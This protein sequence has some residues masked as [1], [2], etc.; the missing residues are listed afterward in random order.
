M[1]RVKGFEGAGGSEG[2][3]GPK[4]AKGPKGAKG[5][6]GAKGSIESK[7]PEAAKNAKESKEVKRAK[8]PHDLRIESPLSTE[9]DR[10]VYD[11][12]GAAMR[13]HTEL[14]PGL[15]ESS[16]ADAFA[17]ELRARGIQFEQ[18]VPIDLVYASTRLGRYRLDLVIEKQLV[19][20]LKTV[21][22]LHPTHSSQMLTYLRAANLPVGILVNFHARHLRDGIRRHVLR[23][24]KSFEP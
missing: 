21:A 20:E 16:Y 14:G 2:A 10:L 8:G 23:P 22:A 19:I 11:V 4:E 9:L 24:T 1:V 6:K 15:L 12:I 13:V 7:R 3:E 17:V 5:A 18:Q